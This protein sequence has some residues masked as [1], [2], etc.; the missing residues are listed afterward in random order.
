VI[1]ELGAFALCLALALSV[2]QVGASVA[3][4]LRASAVLTGAGEGAALAAALAV[5]LAFAVLIYAFVTSDFSVSNVASNSHTDKPILYKVAGAWG[6]H[7][8]SLLLWCLVLTGFGALLARARTGEAGLPFGLKAVAVAVQGG[9]GALFLAFVLFTSNPFGRLDP[10]PVE[11]ASLNPLLQDPALAIHPPMLYA[12]YVGLS[13]CFSLAVAALIEGRPGA[14]FWPAWGRWIRPWALASWALLT[15]GITLGSFWAYYELG[16]GG[17]WFWDP[18]ENASFMPWLAAAALL[19][20]A[21]VTERRGALIGWTVF[22]ALVAF[23]LSMLGAF[24]VRSGVL[25]SVHAFAVD[26]ERGLMLLGILGVTAGAAFGLFALRAGRLTGKALFAPISREGALVINNL[27]LSVA[28]A[29]VL[30]GTLYPLILE[31]A[32][33]ATISVG[34]PYFAVTFTPLMAMALIVLP[35][36]PLLGWK[37]GDL[38]GAMQRLAWAAGL[39]LVFALIGWALFKPALALTAA[40]LA[41]GAWLVLG[42]LAELAERIRLFGKRTAGELARRTRAL[43]LS[44]WGMT[45]AHAGLGLFVLGAVVETGL[46]IETARPLEIGQSITAGPYQA[47]LRAVE[48]VEGPNY[49]AESATLEI[50]ALA[51]GRPE[52]VTAEKRFFP[53]GGQTTTEVGL[54]FHGLDDIYL[55]LGERRLSEAGERAWTVRMNW[56]PWARLIFLGPAL[57]ALGGLLSLLDRRLRTADTRKRRRMSA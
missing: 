9:L 32:G 25:T 34:P 48:V 15:A 44:A 35:M 41:L 56:N 3:G 2:L 31:A 57:M 1:V 12:G 7:E 55:V 16:W 29:T 47:T 24:L 43:P 37:R 20:S 39:S 46:K 21:V 5:A 49:L 42:A 11:G 23:T 6:S 53:A 51:G 8:G 30:V 22:L 19:H 54:S 50:E 40:G 13:V 18:V 26:P 36:G 4:R 10:V 33:G 38:I 27:F 45:A 28:A 17:W 14:G 52:T